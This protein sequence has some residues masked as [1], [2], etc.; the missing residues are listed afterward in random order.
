MRLF[1]ILLLCLPIAVFSQTVSNTETVGIS[2]ERLGRI[3]TFVNKYIQESRLNGA[4]GLIM[5]DGKI[6][7]YKS[8]GYSNIASRT[9]MQ[10]DHIFRIASMTKPIVTTAVM[11]LW[12]E[13]K[14]SLD[15]P[16]SKF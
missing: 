6:V 9:P 12:E 16:I 1:A 4:V 3:D 2:T 11:M 5:K 8:M 13:G 7:Y 10:K 14:F 15:D